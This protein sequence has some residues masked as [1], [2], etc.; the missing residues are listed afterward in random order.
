M[1][2]LRLTLSNSDKVENNQIV[3]NQPW[4]NRQTALISS[5]DKTIPEMLEEAKKV[6]AA[7]PG[8]F[9][10]AWL[11]AELMTNDGFTIG[12]YWDDSLDYAIDETDGKISFNQVKNKGVNNEICA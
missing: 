11:G 3:P 2:V 1:I 8:V 5:S 4:E 12:D 9:S 7:R 6:V 10:I